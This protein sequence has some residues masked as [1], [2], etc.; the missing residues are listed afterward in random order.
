MMYIVN[1][2]QQRGFLLLFLVFI[3]FGL[4]WINTK[5]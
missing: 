2:L 3:V 4:Y 5:L 1:Y